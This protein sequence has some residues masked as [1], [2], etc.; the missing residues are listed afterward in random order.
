MTS[1]RSF[2]EILLSDSDID[3]ADRRRF[4]GV[5]QNESIRLTRL[6]DGI[7]DLNLMEAGE[8]T[9]ETEQFDPDAAIEQAIESCEALAHAAGVKLERLGRV[10]NVTVR[11]N[12]EKLAQVFINLISNAIKYNTSNNPRVT[13][14]S[15]FRKGVYEAH[16]MDNGP[17]IAEAERERIFL[18]FARGAMPRQRGAGLGLAIS[19]QIV[20]RLGGSLSLRQSGGSGCDF[21]VRLNPAAKA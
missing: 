11:G 5:I 10:H 4:I 8:P 13:V 15:V 19:R 21:V 3:E 12:K 20:E 16:V 14:S 17:G 9:W 6:L 18:K 1:I 7:L 2:S